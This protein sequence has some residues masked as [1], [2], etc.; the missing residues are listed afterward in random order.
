MG[1]AGK[2]G[3]WLCYAIARE[4][5]HQFMFYSVCGTKTPEDRRAAVGDFLTRI[6]SGVAVGN[7]EMDYTDGEIHYKTSISVDG[8][9]L[10]VALV[11]NVVDAN[12][13]TMDKYLPGIMAMILDDMT[14]DQRLEIL[15][16]TE[17]RKVTVW[18]N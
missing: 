7:F 12:V 3:K 16:M 2:N 13:V 1:F 4:E 18:P 9:R 15:K 6:N 14:P 11:K 10:T 5:E 17:V 8:D